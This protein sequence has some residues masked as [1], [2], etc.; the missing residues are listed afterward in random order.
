MK[1]RFWNR[2][3]IQ[4]KVFGPIGQ[5]GQKLV[6][7]KRWPAADLQTKL[8]TRVAYWAQLHTSFDWTWMGETFKVR[9]TYFIDNGDMQVVVRDSKTNEMLMLRANF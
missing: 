4:V 3:R 1:T 2:E 9:T 8:M 6:R 5:Y 7:T